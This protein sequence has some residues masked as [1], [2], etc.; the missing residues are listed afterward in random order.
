[1]REIKFRAKSKYTKDFI[2]G[3]LL[4]LENN[5]KIINKDGDYEIIPESVGQY[6]EQ[7]DINGNEIYE[8][9]DV[10]QVNILG[11]TEDRDFIG[12][13]KFYDGTWWIDSGTDAVKL[14]SET[15]ENTI[16][17]GEE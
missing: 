1:M 8:G 3:D 6:T 2:Y 13:V 9:M 15:C 12:E 16:I 4:Q 7:N 10:F 11:A 5:V 14:F 17:T